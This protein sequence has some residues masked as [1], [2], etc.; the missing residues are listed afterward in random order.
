MEKL[1]K[2]LDKA[3]EERQLGGVRSVGAAGVGA[4]GFA[5]AAGRQ[6]DA[7]SYEFTSSRVVTPDAA[8]LEQNRVLTAEASSAVADAYRM[9]RTQVLQRMQERGWRTLSIVSATR[10]DGRTLAAVNLAVMLAADPRYSVLLCDLDL[11][12]PGIAPLFGFGV[13]KGVDDVIAGHA[14]V[15]ECLVHP[16]GYDRLVLLPARAPLPRSSEYL[17]SAATV[18]LVAELRDRYPD[19]IL[20]FDL[21]PVL[22]ADDALAFTPLTDCALMVVSEGATRR[23]DVARTLEILQHT[24]VVGTLLNRSLAGKNIAA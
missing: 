17:A 16:A 8:V 21:P 4:Q 13:D 2:A 10:G 7:G 15:A 9:L 3:R 14:T 23:E 6:T 11:R 18:S 24:P 12:S 5:P 22:L 1:R 20:I 19:R